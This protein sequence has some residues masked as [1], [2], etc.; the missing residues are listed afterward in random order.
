VTPEGE[1]DDITY[2]G[3]SEMGASEDTKKEKPG[4]WEKSKKEKFIH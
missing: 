2:Q 4:N 1:E 3:G